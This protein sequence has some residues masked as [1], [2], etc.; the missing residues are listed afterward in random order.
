[1]DL[2]WYRGRRGAG[3][4]RPVPPRPGRL[5]TPDLER[6]EGGEPAWDSGSLLA[7]LR[8]VP[9]EVGENEGWDDRA[10]DVVGSGEERAA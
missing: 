2:L 5:Q 3:H 8:G 4:G 7:R 10:P 9:N 6:W 1:M